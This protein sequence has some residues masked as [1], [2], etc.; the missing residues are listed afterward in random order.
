MLLTFN[1]QPDTT[2]KVAANAVGEPAAGA[3]AAA[4]APV[5]GDDRSGDKAA[6]V[7]A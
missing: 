4:F 1:C 7:L 3:A 2:V 5:A 6:L